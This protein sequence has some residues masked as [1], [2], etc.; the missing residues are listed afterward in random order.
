MGGQIL[1]RFVCYSLMNVTTFLL[2]V[3]VFAQADSSLF[4]PIILSSSGE[5]GSFFTSE[6]TLTNRRAPDVTLDYRYTAAFGG[7]SGLASD[8]LRSGQQRIIPDAISYL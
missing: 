8:S 1:S 7:G 3:D 2:T 6:L 5:K 4:V